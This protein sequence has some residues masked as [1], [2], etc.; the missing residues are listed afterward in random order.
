MVGLEF[1]TS[2]KYSCPL[3]RSFVANGDKLEDAEEGGGKLGYPHPHCIA[4]VDLNMDECPHQHRQVHPHSRDHVHDDHLLSQLFITQTSV[5]V[6]TSPQQVASVGTLSRSRS[7]HS[8]KYEPDPGCGGPECPPLCHKTNTERVVVALLFGALIIIF[9]TLVL[10]LVYLRETQQ[11]QQY[12]HSLVHFS[13][14]CPLL[15]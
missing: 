9:L 2:N 11:Q 4:S 13:Q 7:R 8:V 14:V 12:S 10:S 3:L 1:D 15:K 6:M 5:A